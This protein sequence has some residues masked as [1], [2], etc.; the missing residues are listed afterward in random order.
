MASQV[1]SGYA[2]EGTQF[3]QD[4]SY[5]LLDTLAGPGDIIAGPITI[6]GNLSVTGTTTL[7]GPAAALSLNTNT[8][9]APGPAA[10]YASAGSLAISAV[11]TASLAGARA[12]VTASAA[13]G[14]NVTAAAGPVNLTASTGLVASAGNAIVVRST[15]PAGATGNAS[16]TSINADAAISGQTGVT[17]ITNTG[18]ALVQAPTINMIAPTGTISLNANGVASRI[19]L[20][21]SNLKGMGV[22]SQSDTATAGYDVQLVGELFVTQGFAVGTGQGTFAAPAQ[23]PQPIPGANVF[24]MVTQKAFLTTGVNAGGVAGVN[25]LFPVSSPSTNWIPLVGQIGVTATNVSAVYTTG[26]SCVAVPAN[27]LAPM[28]FSIVLL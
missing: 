12:D 26:A 13:G 17:V 24:Q 16:L 10:T 27:P 28:T 23:V 7:Q 9:T 3:A 4:N 19:T 20:L 1:T 15:G 14:V 22:L 18:T 5:Y 8:I 25:V 2:T 11:T 21:N 6:T